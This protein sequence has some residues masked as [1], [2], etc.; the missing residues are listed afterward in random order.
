MSVRQAR[1]PPGPPNHSTEGGG[2]PHALPGHRPEEVGGEEEEER[3][4]S[5]PPIP[6]DTGTPTNRWRAKFRSL[7]GLW[8][9]QTS[10]LPEAE[11]A[12]TVSLSLRLDASSDG[13]LPT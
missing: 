7:R 9:G 6:Q 13:G 5:P 10:T 1:R 11:I 4:R 12:M 3:G 2:W 8:G